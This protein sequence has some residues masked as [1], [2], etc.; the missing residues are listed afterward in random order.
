MRFELTTPTL[1][2]L[3]STPELRPRPIGYV[4]HLPARQTPDKAHRYRLGKGP[5]TI[6]CRHIHL[7]PGPAD[8]PI[9]D[10][11]NSK[12]AARPPPPA[13]GAPG[14]RQTIAPGTL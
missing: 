11:S 4:A 7:E 8:N 14:A 5:R 10:P 2:R 9:I 3:C 12:S 1:A 6:S 13:S